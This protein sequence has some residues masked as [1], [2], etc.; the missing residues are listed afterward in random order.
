MDLWTIF[1]GVVVV[2]VFLLLW[3]LTSTR[4]H[5]ETLGIPIDKPIGLLGSGPIDLHN[6][7]IHKVIQDKF[8]KFGTKTYGK[9]DGIIPTVVT[10]DP[11]I[12]KN[13]LV[14]NFES[15]SDVFPE[16]KTCY[17]IVQFTRQVISDLDLHLYL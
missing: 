4:G 16:V 13:V 2:L 8:R 5:L 7:V 17:C 15:F 3:H 9:Y 12:I 6:H 14:K 11:E 10:I 1:L